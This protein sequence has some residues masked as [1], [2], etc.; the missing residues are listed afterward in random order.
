MLRILSWT[1]T[2]IIR[3]FDDEGQYHCIDGPALQYR[4]CAPRWFIHGKQMPSQ[5]E[6]ERYIKM[7]AFW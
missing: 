2:P 7:K 5:K 3:K 4:D 1:Y 6:F